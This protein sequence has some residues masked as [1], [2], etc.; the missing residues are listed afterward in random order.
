MS[1]PNSS[2]V[3]AELDR[4]LAS[5]V[6]VKSPR[7]SRFL[8]FVV[9]ETL[10]GTGNRIKEYVVGLE[11]FDKRPDFDPQTDSSVRTEASKLRARLDRYYDREGLDDPVTISIPKGSYIPVFGDRD[12]GNNAGLVCA[13]E[14]LSIAVLPFVNMSSSK[15]DEYFSDGLADEIL[16]VLAHIPGLKVTARTSSFAFRGKELDIRKIAETLGVRSILQGSARRAGNR[17]RVTAQ[18]I[19]ALDGFHL[20]SER[21]D[22]ELADVFAVQDEIAA[23]IAGALQVTLAGKPVAH[24]PN[25]PA[26]DAFLRGRHHYFKNTP[27]AVTRASEYFEQAIALDPE[28]AEPHVGLGLHY[29]F[30]VAYGMRPAREVMPLVRAEAKTALDLFPSEPGAHALLGVVATTYDY[31]WK[32]A[33]EQFRRAMATNPV[34]PEVHVRHALY[35]LVP[36]GRFKDAIAEMEQGLERDPLSILLRSY[37]SF[38]LSAAGMYDRAIAEVRKALEIDEGFWAA[39]SMMASGYAFQGMFDEALEWAETAHRLAPWDSGAAGLLAGLCSG[40]GDERR[41]KEILATP[42]PVGIGMMFY[43]L[44]RSEIDLAADWYEKAI[45]QHAPFVVVWATH[46]YTR[47]LRASPRWPALARMMNLPEAN[48]AWPEL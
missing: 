30:L 48:A 31:D 21:Y 7:M 36:R 25:L 17:I 18:L 33:E 13:A 5:Q 8:K 47:P 40:T 37:L 15:D 3:R 45:E 27:D 10:A 46:S 24:Q 29:F 44:L 43:H 32:E 16:N 12:R 42:M 9:D 22:R 39:Q 38:I 19:N 4:I 34:P 6:F 26:Y 11:V 41:A 1:V 28:Y 20:W 23:A 2:T 35:N 14:K